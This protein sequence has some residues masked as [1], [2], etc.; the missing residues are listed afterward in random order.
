MKKLSAEKYASEDALMRSMYYNGIS[1]CEMSRMSEH[2][3]GRKLG[4]SRITTRLKRIGVIVQAK[5]WNKGLTLETDK[6]GRIAKQWKTFQENADKHINYGKALSEET[7][8]K[9]SKSRKEFLKNNPHKVGYLLNHSSKESYPEKYFANLFE[10]IGVV[11]T[12]YMRVG[13]FTLDFCD[14]DRKIDLE[15]DGGTHLLPAVKEKDDRRDKQLKDL[16]WRVIRVSWS[17]F[18]KLSPEQK[19][20]EFQNILKD[21]K[22]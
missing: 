12:R 1:A 8:Q 4:V 13:L 10:N 11:L 20:N 18:Q 21:L 5:A 22:L 6:T 16:G 9:I 3:F 2:I 15:I 19:Q 17:K 7:K 14:L